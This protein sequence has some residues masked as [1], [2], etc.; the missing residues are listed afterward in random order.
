[1]FGSLRPDPGREGCLATGELLNDKSGRDAPEAGF[2][3]VRRAR[4]AARGAR[5]AGLGWTQALIKRRP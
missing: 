1:L 2:A 5:E 4:A 3:A